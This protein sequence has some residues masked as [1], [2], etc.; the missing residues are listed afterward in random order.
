[1]MQLALQSMNAVHP[2]IYVGTNN[3]AASLVN[4]QLS[5][6]FSLPH[7]NALYAQ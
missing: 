3:Q 2:S 4:F 7:K 1:M 6:H 5:L